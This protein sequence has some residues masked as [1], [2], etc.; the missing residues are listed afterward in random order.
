M[1]TRTQTSSRWQTLSVS[2]PTGAIVAPLDEMSHGTRVLLTGATGFVGSHLY[3]ELSAQGFEVVCGT[4]DPEAAAK[5][6]PTRRYC[7]IDVS[8]EGSVVSALDQVD[9]AIYLV[10]S[11]ATSEG[12][13]ELEQ[14][15]ASL[16]RS[17]AD[18]R[19]LE[20]IV[21]IGGMHPRGKASRH[22]ASRLRTGEILRTGSTKTVELQATMIIG[23]GS[24]SFRIVRDLAARLPAMVLPRWLN[25][26]SEP[27]GIR[28][29]A[30][31]VVHALRMPLEGSRVFTLPGAE[32]LSAR[33]ILVRT[34]KAL[35][36]KPK[37]IGVPVI[38][39]RLS[40]YWIRWVTRANGRVATELVEG[41]RSDILSTGS[42]IWDE[43]PNYVRTPFDQ[44][45]REALDE[46][47]RS[48]PPTTRRV[49][50]ALHRIAPGY[51]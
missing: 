26:M 14:R 17:K 2:V 12:Y 35:G 32:R 3:P 29:V 33:D 6:D 11:I 49:E 37:I 23:G 20:R 31:A 21:Y 47:S 50:Q 24:E 46:E 28:D 22:L 38:T 36:Q 51:R 43:M 13:A 39:P 1:T 19:G 48:I 16:F 40:S 30:A 7:R 34:A 4:R 15:G 25:S 27:V 8:D 5:L 18:A 44:A 41:L 10:H 42:T 45:I 9:A